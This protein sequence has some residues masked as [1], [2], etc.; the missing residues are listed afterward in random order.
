MNSRFDYT[1]L[2]AIENAI[3]TVKASP[4][5]LGGVAGSG[6]GIGGPTGGIVGYLPQTRVAYDLTEAETSGFVASGSSLLDN[7]NHIRYRIGILEDGGAATNLIVNDEGSLVASGVTTLNFV[8]DSVE[9]TSSTPGTVDITISG[10][11]GSGGVDVYE[12]GIL[13]LSD[14]TGLDFVGAS[15]TISGSTVIVQISGS[16]PPITAKA[17]PFGDADGSLN[18]DYPYFVYNEPS[19]QLYLGKFVEPNPFGYNFYPLA[20]ISPNDNLSVFFP[21][22]AN[23]AGSDGNPNG[24]YAGYRS[25]G[26]FEAPE[27][28]A[29]GDSLVSFAGYGYDTDTYY[30]TARMRFRA[31]DDWDPGVD[32]GTRMEVDLVPKGSTTRS[33]AITITNDGVDIPEGGTYNINGV[34]HSHPGG[35]ILFQR[36]LSASMHVADGESL[37]IARYI[38]FSNYEITFDGDGEVALV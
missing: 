20:I 8:G 12:E 29:S 13:V 22:V 19:K 10:G 31:I 37:V 7:L 18:T 25:R 34:P 36:N 33:R 4:L 14:A 30:P 21:L 32:R 1:I 28:I 5:V 15:T 9:V 2:N 26:T 23:G 24:V 27:T 16:V 38:N 3:K 11:S 35:S 17:V 6:G